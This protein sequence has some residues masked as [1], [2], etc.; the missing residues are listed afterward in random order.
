[1]ANALVFIIHHI[2]SSVMADKA[3]LDLLYQHGIELAQSGRFAEAL[4]R[5]TQLTNLNP[6]DVSG[7]NGR[8]VMLAA[9]GRLPEALAAVEQ[10]IR[11]DPEDHYAWNNRGCYLRGLK[12]FP[13]AIQ[14]FDRAIALVPDYQ[15]ARQNRQEVLHQM[16]AEAAES[17]TSAKRGD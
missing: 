14:S 3:V 13:E 8:G 4:D 2:T 5:F 12:R 1:V 9:L 16:A 6:E 10:V 7:W 15:E 11:C 17:K